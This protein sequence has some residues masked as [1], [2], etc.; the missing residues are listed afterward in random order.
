ML[1]LYL[2]DYIN[3][4]NNSFGPVAETIPSK[5]LEEYV[6]PQE[7]QAELTALN[8]KTTKTVKKIFE[9]A[10]PEIVTN[11]KVAI[12]FT[13]SDGRNEK[14][15]TLSPYEIQV[16]FNERSDYNPE[17]IE[18]ITNFLKSNRIFHHSLEIKFLDSDCLISFNRKKDLDEKEYAPFPSRALDAQYLTGNQE[19]M[20]RYKEIFFTQLVHP[21]AGKKITQ[22]RT[23]AFKGNAYRALMAAKTNDAKENG[24][25]ATTGEIFY[26]DG[27][28]RSIK[29]VKYAFLRYTQ[30]FTTI[31]FCRALNGGRISIA[32][33][34][35]YPRSIIERIQ[36]LVDNRLM[37]KENGEFL[38]MN[39]A[40]S[41]IMY[42]QS[43][44]AHELNPSREEGTALKVHQ[45]LLRSIF[46][47][48]LAFDSKTKAN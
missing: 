35:A 8:Q 47:G 46:E 40:A 4:V 11:R 27:E 22:F 43:Q 28:K 19:V 36:W 32:D 34:A 14:L 18:K 13:G 12:S 41:L 1:N 2:A 3:L 42:S 45:P 16:I 6:N 38:S 33:A 37:K 29:S 17:L 21:D 44:R 15:S 26:K 39:Y 7:F 31:E 23:S 25:D 30:Y 10:I 48:F 5:I 24:F 20:Q 9:E